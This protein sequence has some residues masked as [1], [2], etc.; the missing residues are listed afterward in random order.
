MKIKINFTKRWIYTL[1]TLGILII[2][3]L[4]VYALTVGGIEKPGHPSLNISIPLNCGIGQL[5]QF[6]GTDIICGDIS[7]SGGNLVSGMLYRCQSG[8]T[9]IFGSVCSKG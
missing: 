1:V 2:I 8:D 6:N 3:G 7:A 4:G 9:P 5:M